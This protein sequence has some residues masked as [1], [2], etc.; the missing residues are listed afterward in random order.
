MA[1]LKE[2]FFG[3]A[4]RHWIFSGF[5]LMVFGIWSVNMA[6]AWARYIEMRPQVEAW[7]KEYAYKSLSSR[8]EYE[9]PYR[10]AAPPA[11]SKA[12]EQVLDRDEERQGYRF[13][14]LRA[15]SL[16]LLHEE[17]VFQFVSRQGNG[18]QRMP[19]VG[20]AYV[21]PWGPQEP[22]RPDRVVDSTLSS[23]DASEAALVLPEEPTATA[24]GLPAPPLPDA[25]IW[26][27]PLPTVKQVNLLHSFARDRFL[28][29][30]Q[31][32]DV[33]SVDRVA[34]FLPHAFTWRF[35][36]SDFIPRIWK[37]T[38]LELVSLLKQPT[39][40]VYLSE[41][42]PKM[43][44]LSSVKTRSLDAFETSA[45]KRLQDGEELETSA[46]QNR[47]VMLGA[48]RAG[49]TCLQC[50]GVA[51]GT[52]LGAFSYELRRDPPLAISRQAVVQQ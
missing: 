38:R 49:K 47:I 16:R 3:F 17:S 19:P 25:N 21:E 41:H 30:E 26:A 2:R 32:G 18:F 43:D 40:R 15:E 28:D 44:E 1:T 50:H 7:R 14:R 52:L 33:I 10:A 48:V 46:T 34:G 13:N 27:P 45:L 4:R 5:A 8:L 51:R 23:G 20:P 11:L 29:P 9:R 12:S 24:P 39:P 31:Y 37:T 6:F 42:L 35:D 36:V 22:V